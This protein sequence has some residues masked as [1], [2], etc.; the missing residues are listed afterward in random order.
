MLLIIFITLMI[1]WFIMTKTEAFCPLIS[2]VDPTSIYLFEGI[3]PK[4]EWWDVTHTK[5]LYDYHDMPLMSD[6]NMN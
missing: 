5:K 3:S 6:M 4:E 2:Q 1:L